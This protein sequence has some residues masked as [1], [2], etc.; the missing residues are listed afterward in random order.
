[1]LDAPTPNEDPTGDDYAFE[2]GAEKTSGG[3]GFADVWKRDHFGWEYKGKKRDLKAAYNQLLLYREALDNPPLLVVCDLDRFEVHTNFTGTAK[4]VYPFSLA[5]LEADPSEPLRVLRA[6]MFSPEDLKPDQTREELTEE[7]ARHFASIAS[8]LRDKGHDPDQVAHFLT[9]LLF[10]LYAEDSGLLPAGL[11]SRLAVATAKSPDVFVSGLAELFEKMSNGGG[12][13]GTEQIQWFNGGLFDGADVL[14]LDTKEVA[15]LGIVAALDWSQI[16]PAIFGT[17]FERGLDPSKRSQ[18]GAHYT[19][20]LSIE[21]LVEAVVERPLRRELVAM[22]EQVKTLLAAGHKP[23]VAPSR[24][25]RG[26]NDPMRPWEE[27]L[28][29]L[30]SVTVLDPACGSGNFLYI[31]LHTLKDLER[32]VL[33]WGSEVFGVPVQLPEV[34]PSAVKGIELNH[35]AAELARVTIWI[36]EIQWMLQHGFAYLRDPILRPL[37]AVRSVDAVI[38]LSDPENPQEPDWPDA[39]FIVGN[40]PFLG[41]KFLRRRLGSPYVDALFRVYDGRVPREADFVTYWFEKA[42]A[43]VES[44]RVSRAGLLATQGIRSGANRR[45]LERIK[46]SG[47]I[48]MAISDRKWVL[49]GAA[50]HVSFVAFDD[51]SETERELDGDVVTEINTDLTSGVDVTK[52]VRLEENRDTAFMGD[53]K[54]GAFDIDEATARAM[55]D[56]PNPDGSDNAD[57]VRPWVNGEDVNQRPRGMWIIDFLPGTTEQQAALYEEPFEY[58]VKHVK[59]ERE[60]NERPAYAERWWLHVEPRPELRAAIKGLKRYIGTAR[61]TK[62]RIFVWLPPKTLPDSQ[63]IVIARED[64]FTFGVLHSRVHESWA[65]RTG[66]QLRERESGFRYTPTTTFETFPFPRPTDEQRTAIS[67]A[68]RHLVKLRDGWLKARPDRTLTGLYNEDPTW[69][70]HAHVAL[71]KAVFNAYGWPD[72]LDEEQLLTRLLALNAERAS[73]GVLTED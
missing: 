30:R 51:G 11:L 32:E 46:E 67:D 35:Y 36:G 49:D 15:V 66:S 62:H 24:A 8:S 73:E 54:G 40:P 38:D 12:L 23:R 4:K 2:K 56:A 63:I 57:V 25:K 53:T 21:L 70:H 48:F 47:G 71:D 6:V 28:K 39:E 29:R 55:L 17:L 16:E 14:P 20:R 22:Q 31:A 64:D 27:F 34:N 26:K 3:D 5:D 72:D 59:S 43:L 41:G 42:R 50:V 1:L 10:C 7:A 33:H 45:V 69:L 68:A 19:D 9:K 13:Y 65:R 61:L 37:D 60:A 58:L 52:A 44:G 18:L